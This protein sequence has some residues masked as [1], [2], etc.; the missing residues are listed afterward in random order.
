MVCQILYLAP[1]GDGISLRETLERQ[2]PRIPR[3]AASLGR[4]EASRAPNRFLAL[5]SGLSIT[6]RWEGN[7]G[8]VRYAQAI[9]RARRT[10]LL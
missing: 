8:M 10:L 6:M 3:A 9:P 2:T 5:L 4:A 1:S 7:E